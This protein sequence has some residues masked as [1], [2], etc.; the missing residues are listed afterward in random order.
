MDSPSHATYF[1]GGSCQTSQSFCSALVWQISWKTFAKRSEAILK[2]AKGFKI[3]SGGVT[4]RKPLD[5]A[6]G[7]VYGVL[8]GCFEAGWL[9]ISEPRRKT[10]ILHFAVYKT[11]NAVQ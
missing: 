3:F 5:R 10:L 1:S 8:A 6:H 2:P 7:A 9:D 11:A 4:V